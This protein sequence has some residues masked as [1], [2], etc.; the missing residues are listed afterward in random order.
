MRFA[1]EYHTETD[2]QT[3]DMYPVKYW[4]SFGAVSS[5]CSSL[6][7]TFP[8]PQITS[9]YD[10][11]AVTFKKLVKG[12]AYSVTGV[13]EVITKI[14]PHAYALFSLV[15]VRAAHQAAQCFTSYFSYIPRRSRFSLSSNLFRSVRATRILCRLV[16]FYPSN[17]TIQCPLVLVALCSSTSYEWVGFYF[18][19]GGVPRKYD[20]AGSH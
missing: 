13:D 17:K 8:Q 20:K 3:E 11:E 9:S 18:H 14:T 15:E 7:L 16:R 4:N 2:R 6:L 19:I 12:H 10:M 5:L 1:L